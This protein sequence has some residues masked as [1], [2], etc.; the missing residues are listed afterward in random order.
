MTEDNVSPQ[1]HTTSNVIKVDQSPLSG[2]LIG[3]DGSDVLKG[4]DE[5]DTTMVAVAMTP[6]RV[7]QV[8][9]RYTAMPAMT[10]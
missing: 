6:F 1:D 8:T 5:A 10:R 2:P 4:S 9:T 3:T 7:S